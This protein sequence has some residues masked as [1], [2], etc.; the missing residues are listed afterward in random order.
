MTK[1]IREAQEII[2]TQDDFLRELNAEIARLEAMLDEM[3]G[4]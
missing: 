4:A 1:R 2:K 3:K